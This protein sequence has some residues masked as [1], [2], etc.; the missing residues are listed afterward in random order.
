MQN[1]LLAKQKRRKDRK[2]L[3][4]EQGSWTGGEIFE[5]VRTPIRPLSCF[6]TA[7]PLLLLSASYC[8][9]DMIEAVK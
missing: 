9:G 6:R 8:G 1:K 7:F 3:V 4:D 5:V 2:K